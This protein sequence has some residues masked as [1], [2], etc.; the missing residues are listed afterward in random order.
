MS[1]EERWDTVVKFDRLECIALDAEHL[2]LSRAAYAQFPTE[3]ILQY[4][5]SPR[6]PEA[7]A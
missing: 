6:S 5:E 3:P 1:R 2:K 4:C 7:R